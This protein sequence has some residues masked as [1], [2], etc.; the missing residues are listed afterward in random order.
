MPQNRKKT[1][2][3]A[4]SK[5]ALLPRLSQYRI[6]GGPAICAAPAQTPASEPTPKVI[7]R[8]DGP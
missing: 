4:R 5:T 2:R 7:G 3:L 6:T 1:I 8:V